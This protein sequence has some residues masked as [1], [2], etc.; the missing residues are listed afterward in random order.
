MVRIN[1]GRNTCSI[2]LAILSRKLNACAR[3]A[4]S[5][6]SKSPGLRPVAS[7][8]N[9]FSDGISVLLMSGATYGR[10]RGCAS[11]A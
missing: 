8:S 3:V 5:T 9:L 11:D 2:V 7:G 1:S 6:G 4:A 10:G